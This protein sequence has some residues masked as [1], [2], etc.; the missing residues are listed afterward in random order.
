MADRGSNPFEGVTDFFSELARM[1]EYGVHGREHAHE[2]RARTHA[3]AWVPPTDIF[4][5]EGDLVIRVEVAGVRP[6]DVDITFSQNVLTVSGMRDTEEGT[7]GRDSFYIRER[8]SGAFRRAVTLPEGTDDDQISAEFENGIVEIV[9][10]DAVSGSE[11]RR[12]PLRDRS[13]S[14]TRRSL[15]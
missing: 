13:S 8:F 7:G 10:R 15:G 4:A 9:V 2:R 3:S 5:R 6:D 14:P 12:I 1:R 11:A